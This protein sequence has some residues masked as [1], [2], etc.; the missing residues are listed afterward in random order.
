[1]ASYTAYI[2]INDR[3]ILMNVE[4]FLKGKGFHVIT[5][6]DELYSISNPGPVH[7]LIFDTE[8][9][10]GSSTAIFDLCKRHNNLP[11]FPLVFVSD[12][13]ELRESACDE[14]PHESLHK[15][16]RL[17]EIDCILSELSAGNTTE[18]GS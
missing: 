10:F 17:Y 14:P 16:F 9:F 11:G 4:S 8:T 18:N 3:Y 13:Y 15:P 7:I 12:N 5:P 6:P 2:A 1:M